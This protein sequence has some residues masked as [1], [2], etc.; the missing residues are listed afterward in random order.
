MSRSTSEQAVDTPSEEISRI[1]DLLRE[2]EQLKMTV[3]AREEQ[4]KQQREAKEKLVA[5][6]EAEISALQAKITEPSS[7]RVGYHN[8]KCKDSLPKSQQS[9]HPEYQQAGLIS[10]D[11]NQLTATT[12]INNRSGRSLIEAWPKKHTVGQRQ[13]TEAICRA[14]Q[15]ILV[16]LRKKTF[17]G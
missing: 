1:D 9:N 6:K 10:A 16:G 4:L 12:G 7:V 5:E 17:F 11:P 15:T 13:I 14:H 2:N 3:E 8:N